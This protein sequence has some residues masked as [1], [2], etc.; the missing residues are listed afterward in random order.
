MHYNTSISKFPILPKEW[1]YSV[2]MLMQAA[3]VSL[4]MSDLHWYLV[5]LQ[6]MLGYGLKLVKL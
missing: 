6:V 1:L 4:A 2:L 3:V 5:Q